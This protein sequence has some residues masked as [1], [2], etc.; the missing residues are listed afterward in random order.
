MLCN[1]PEGWDRGAGGSPKRVGRC[2]Y[3]H[4]H[5]H[6]HSVYITYIII[7]TYYTYLMCNYIIIHYNVFFVYIFVYT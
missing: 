5:T 4:T 7:H 1:D 6:T 3:I 2:I